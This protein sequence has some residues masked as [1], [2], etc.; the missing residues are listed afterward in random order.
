MERVREDA[1]MALTSR[2]AQSMS[3][4]KTSSVLL[5]HLQRQNSSKSSHSFS[6][7]PNTW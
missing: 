7:P 6:S 3:A 2:T 5:F 1:S 4:I